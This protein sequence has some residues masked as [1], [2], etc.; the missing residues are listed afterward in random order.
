MRKLSSAEEAKADKVIAK[1]LSAAQE[2]ATE[3]KKAREA[4]SRGEGA[5][6][7]D[8]RWTKFGVQPGGATAPGGLPG[9]S[10]GGVGRKG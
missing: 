4:A 7:Q 10:R 5:P 9:P 2:Q 3:A 8:N 1:L 6:I